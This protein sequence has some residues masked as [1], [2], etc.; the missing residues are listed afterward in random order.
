MSSPLSHAG[1]RCSCVTLCHIEDRLCVLTHEE[2]F[3]LKVYYMYEIFISMHVFN[4]RKIERDEEDI[5]LQ[6]GR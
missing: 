4:P 6:M 1:Q 5:E 3:A 2:K